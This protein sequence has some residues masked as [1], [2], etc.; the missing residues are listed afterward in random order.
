MGAE[1]LLIT[2]HFSIDFD[3]VSGPAPVNLTSALRHVGR[4]A[5]RPGS[6]YKR[7][8]Q[9]KTSSWKR[10]VSYAPSRDEVKAIVRRSTERA[11]ETKFGYSSGGPTAVTTGAPTMGLIFGALVQGVS[12]A[13]RIGQQVRTTSFELRLGCDCNAALA[14][15]IR[16]L[17]VRDK[18]SNG[19]VP[20]TAV[21]WFMDKTG[22]NSWYSVYDPSTVGPRYDI[23]MDKSKVLNIGGGNAQTPL[24]EM[25]TWKSTSAK[26]HGKVTYN[27]GNAG[28]VAD[29]NKGAI[30]LAVY[31]DAVATGPSYVFD[32]GVKFKD[33]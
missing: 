31:T 10:R 21:E 29:I 27:I 1:G 33:A 17:V 7:K 30:I 24:R 26:G 22:A 6:E 2:R 32:F 11:L 20:A 23:L 9:Y 3:H 28:T 4:R 5:A 14:S 15:R 8:R 18:Q 25:I 12:N 13:T 19:A 16:V